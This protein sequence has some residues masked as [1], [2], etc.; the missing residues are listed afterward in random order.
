MDRGWSITIQEV[1]CM[2]GDGLGMSG[3]GLGSVLISLGML[4][5]RGSLGMASL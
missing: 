2:R 4:Y 5:L 3:M 1:N